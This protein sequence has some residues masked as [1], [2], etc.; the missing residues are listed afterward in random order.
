[1]SEKDREEIR[2]IIREELANQ[3]KQPITPICLHEW[4]F[5]TGGS[6]CRKCGFSS[7]HLKIHYFKAIVL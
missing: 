7:E 6:Y 2:Q 1:M 4:V 5:T 3:V